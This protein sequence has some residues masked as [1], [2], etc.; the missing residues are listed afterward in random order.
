[1]KYHP[2]TLYR[3][4]GKFGLVSNRADALAGEGATATRNRASLII[5]RAARGRL[6]HLSYTSITRGK[7]LVALVGRKE[8]S[9]IAVRNVSSGSWW[10]KLREWLH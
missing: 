7:R 1:L 2:A 5:Y 4:L 3:E 8:A 6:G 10:S 9:A